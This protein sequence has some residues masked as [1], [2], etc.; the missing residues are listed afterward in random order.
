[1]A[2]PGRGEIECRLPVGKRAN[3]AGSPPDLAQNA[4]ERIVIWHVLIGAL[5]HSSG[6]RISAAWV[7]RDEGVGS[8]RDGQ[9][10][11]YH[12]LRARVGIWP[13]SRLARVRCE[14]ESVVVVWPVGS[15]VSLPTGRSR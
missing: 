3:D 7:D 9:A 11:S 6:E 13:P 8:T 2:Q 10:V 12:E 5:I 4:F 14:R 15:R 1:M